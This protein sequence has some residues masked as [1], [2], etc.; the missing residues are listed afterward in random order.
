LHILSPIGGI[1]VTP[2]IEDLMA[3]SVTDGEAL[4]EIVDTAQVRARMYVPEF[5]MHDL[6]LGAPVRLDLS[7]RFK[8]FSGRI[9]SVSPTTAA[10]ADGLVPKAQL[11]GMNAPHYY[12]AAVLLQND[13]TLSAGMTGLAKIMVRRESLAARSWRFFSELLGRR[14]W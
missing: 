6:H 7:G 2:H 10:I 9:L 11:Q 4:V 12:A 3:S 1:V 14:I 5:A 13:G 8:T